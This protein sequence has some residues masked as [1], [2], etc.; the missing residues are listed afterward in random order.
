MSSG[1]WAVPSK[2]LAVRSRLHADDLRLL[3]LE[4]FQAAGLYIPPAEHLALHE[5]AIVGLD[6]LTLTAYT[7]VLRPNPDGTTTVVLGE[8][9]LSRAERPGLPSWGPVYPEAGHVMTTDVESMQTAAYWVMQPEDEV[10]RFYDVVMTSS[11]FVKTRRD[12]YVQ[13][14]VQ[15]S[16]A[17]SPARSGV[18]VLLTRQRAEP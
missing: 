16:V 9:F 4:Q 12:F 11:G 15:M 7:A 8:S 13:G 2:L 14:D 17:Y 3:L 1:R 6:P 18:N 10:R 5:V